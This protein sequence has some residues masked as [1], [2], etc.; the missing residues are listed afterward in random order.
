MTTLHAP[1]PAALPTTDSADV[2]AATA[3][4]ASL[5]QV[6]RYAGM[7]RIARADDFDFYTGL[8]RRGFL[9]SAIQFA[10]HAIEALEADGAVDR[11]ELVD[12][13][14]RSML[15]ALLDVRRAGAVAATRAVVHELGRARM[16]ALAASETLVPL[17]TRPVRGA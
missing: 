16:A 11:A 10:R 9:E 1:G 17:A 13:L 15:A 5:G 6:A 14:E 7:L 3:V 2:G 8:V 4:A 12:M